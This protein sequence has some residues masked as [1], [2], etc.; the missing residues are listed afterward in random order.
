MDNPQ[1]PPS[2]THGTVVGI[3]D[4]GSI[5]VH[6]DTGSSLNVIYGVDSVKKI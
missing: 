1:A 6:W 2:G 4:I 3:D 5:L